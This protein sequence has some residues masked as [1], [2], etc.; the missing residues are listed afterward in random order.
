MRDR[1]IH[2]SSLRSTGWWKLSTSIPAQSSKQ[3]LALAATSITY[4]KRRLPFQDIAQTSQTPGVMC[5]FAG[6]SPPGDGTTTAVECS[7]SISVK[8]DRIRFMAEQVTNKVTPWQSDIS[9]NLLP[10][11]EICRW[12]DAPW[13]LGIRETHFVH[14]VEFA[15][16]FNYRRKVSLWQ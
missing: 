7:K 15:S 10:I 1:L 4:L 14:V 12:K 8:F 2:V 11:E 16:T 5:S 3:S 9:A 6:Q 13:A